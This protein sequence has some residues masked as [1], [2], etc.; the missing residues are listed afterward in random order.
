MANLQQTLD[1]LQPYVVGIRY[2]EKRPI[3]DVVFKDGWTVLESDLIT[4][5]KGSQELNYYM[6]YSNK[7][8]I[9]LDELLLYI[10]ATIKL[11]I[12]REKKHELL[13]DKVNELK[14]LFKKTPLATLK[15][16]K[17]TFNE[18]ELLPEI[19]EFDLEENKDEPVAETQTQVIEEDQPVNEPVIVQELDAE[20]RELL[21]EE[22]RAENFRL[23][24]QKTKS[25]GQIKKISSTVELPPK[26]TIEEVVSQPD[27]D[28]APDE[29]CDK[30]MGYKG[31]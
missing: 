13:K 17:F 18:E 16:L 22:Q 5:E 27:C 28:C 4:K 19:N 12:E 11:N 14:I 21:E 3:I 25:N 29:F 20:E 8:G 26:R 7:E 30:C 6:V 2:L 23:L 10:E 15:R 9:G 1:A 31:L 24:Q